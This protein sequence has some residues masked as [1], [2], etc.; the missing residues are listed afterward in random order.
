MRCYVVKQKGGKTLPDV[1]PGLLAASVLGM[2]V[3]VI[4]H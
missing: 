4:S 1:P 3:I 2:N